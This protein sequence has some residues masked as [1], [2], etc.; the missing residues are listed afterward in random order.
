MDVT[1]V[2][3][4]YYGKNTPRIVIYAGASPKIAFR[5]ADDFALTAEIIIQVWENG[6]MVQE[7]EQ[8]NIK[9]K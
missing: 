7:F 4:G 6:V 2:V 9:N 1:Y 3:T 5:Y 8:E